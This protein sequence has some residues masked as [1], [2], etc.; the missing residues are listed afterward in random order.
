[1]TELF[2]IYPI[3]MWQRSRVTDIIWANI[4]YNILPNES[5]LKLVY[6][7][8]FPLVKTLAVHFF[9]PKCFH[10]VSMSIYGKCG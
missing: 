8:N 5:E 10:R 9:W 6:Q 4:L 7:Q 2:L 1:M 3:L